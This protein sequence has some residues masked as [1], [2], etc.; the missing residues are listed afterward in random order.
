MNSEMPYDPNDYV[1]S[2]ENYA[3]KLLNRSLKDILGKELKQVYS[4]KG[5]LGQI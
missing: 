2:I 3:Q 4:G 5:K 1:I